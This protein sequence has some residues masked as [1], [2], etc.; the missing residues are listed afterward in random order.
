[1]D[2]TEF[3]K[4]PKGGCSSKFYPDRIIMLLLGFILVNIGDSPYFL[5]V[6]CQQS[7]VTLPFILPYIFKNMNLIPFRFHPVRT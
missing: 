7:C 2:S 6:K 5:S 4:H 3:R 1:M